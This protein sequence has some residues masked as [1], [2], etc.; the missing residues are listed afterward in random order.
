MKAEKVSHCPDFCVEGR[1]QG[2]E[3][4]ESTLSDFTGLSGTG[5]CGTLVPTE[6][7]GAIMKKRPDQD[8]ERKEG[9]S[10][11]RRKIVEMI[12]RIDNPALLDRIYRFIKYIYIHKT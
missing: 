5:V 7:G 11:D 12:D 9:L 8:H 3:K 4:Q 2:V 6:K 1:N 10:Q